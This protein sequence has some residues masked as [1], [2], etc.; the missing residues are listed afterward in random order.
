MAL[1]ILPPEN[2]SDHYALAGKLA[3]A[4]E[5]AR[6][7]NHSM[8]DLMKVTAS[9]YQGPGGKDSRKMVFPVPFAPPT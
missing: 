3:R 4:Q 5:V 6:R 1:G 2:P 7:L 8:G 9:A